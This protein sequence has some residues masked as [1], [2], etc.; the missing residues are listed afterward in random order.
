MYN[1][2]NIWNVSEVNIIWSINIFIRKGSDDEELRAIGQEHQQRTVEKVLNLALNNNADQTNMESSSGLPKDRA[3]QH[4]GSLDMLT[5]VFPF[6]PK[7]AVESALETCG[8][9]VAKAVQQLVGHQPHHHSS[10]SGIIPTSNAEETPTMTSN[11]TSI[12]GNHLLVTASGSNK[13]AFLPTS[14]SSNLLPAT[15]SPNRPVYAPTSSSASSMVYPS[16]LRMMS[17]YPAA[18]GMMSFLHP[19]AYFAAAA[20]AAAAAASSPHSYPWL[21]PNHYRPSA[22]VTPQHHQFQHLC[23]PGCS[24]C[25]ISTS[26]GTSSSSSSPGESASYNPNGNNIIKA[27][28]NM[29]FAS[30]SPEDMFKSNLGRNKD[31]LFQ[32]S[33]SSNNHW[34]TFLFVLQI[35]SFALLIKTSDHIGHELMFTGWV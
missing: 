21:F 12:V 24:V 7:N 23:L 27:S 20:S 5:R 1:S 28:N 8:G 18:A 35:N 25:P 33:S 34:S 17:S 32:Q 30:S 15:S 2:G 3:V 4:H 9:D 11:K 14:S 26:A 10:S 22:L 16:A 19:S 13:S 31:L 29:M 6:H